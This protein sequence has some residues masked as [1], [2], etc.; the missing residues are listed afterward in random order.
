MPAIELDGL[1]KRYGD[2]VANEEVTFDVERGEIFGYLGPNG[3]GKTT[4]IRLLLGLIKPSSGTASVLGTDIRDRR[5]LTATKA[6]VGYLPDTLG[7]HERLTGRRVLAY[8]G[9]MR[10]DDRRDEQLHRRRWPTPRP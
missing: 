7:F 6:R 10:G 9:R 8:Y 3:A 1:S 5:A 4:T 2:V